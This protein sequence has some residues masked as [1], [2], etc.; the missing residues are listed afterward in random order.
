PPKPPPPKP[1]KPPPDPPPKPPPLLEPPPPPPIPFNS[2]HQNK[3]FEP[4]PLIIR[5]PLL[6]PPPPFDIKAKIT[7]IIMITAIPLIPPFPSLTRCLR[8]ALYS[9][10]VYEIIEFVALSKPS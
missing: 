10:L 7:T 6:L 3:S 4:L 5:P 8:S 9:P 2:I 1:P